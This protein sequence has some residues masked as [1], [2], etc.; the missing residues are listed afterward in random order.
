MGNISKIQNGETFKIVERK[1][2][3]TT[4]VDPG[5][6]TIGQTNQYLDA[7]HMKKAEQEISQV[8]ENFKDRYDHNGKV[9]LLV[10]GMDGIAVVQ[11]TG[12]GISLHELGEQGGALTHFALT[13]KK[14]DENNDYIIT[15][16][17]LYTSWGEQLGGSAMTIGGATAAGAATGST[18]G[19][20]GGTVV[21]PG[22][23]TA[24]GWLGMGALGAAIS[25]I[26]STLWEGARTI[27]YAVSDEYHTDQA[28]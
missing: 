9:E 5:K 1:L 17:E 11:D 6:M 12:N 22:V 28:R 7:K 18:I 14:Y 20:M 25:G 23:G 26:G 8:K 16:D 19:A 4:S 3:G 2:K 24:V 21:V 27:G 13:L 10:E 15:E